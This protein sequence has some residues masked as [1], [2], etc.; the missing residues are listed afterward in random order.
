MGLLNSKTPKKPPP[1]PPNKPGG[2]VVEGSKEPSSHRNILVL[3]RSGSQFFDK[4]GDLAHE[5]YQ[6]IRLPDGRTTM[7]RIATDLTPQGLVNHD[8]PRLHPDYPLVL[9]GN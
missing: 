7:Q 4:D 3:Q 9:V 8:H 2:N 5:F 6:E 1:P